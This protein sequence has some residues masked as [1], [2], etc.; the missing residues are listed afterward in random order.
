MVFLSIMSINICNTIFP[1]S[2]GWQIINKNTSA[3]F[4]PPFFSYYAFWSWIFFNHV[5]LLLLKSHMQC[6]HL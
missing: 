1:Q 3:L 6:M 5:A 4:Y 2:L